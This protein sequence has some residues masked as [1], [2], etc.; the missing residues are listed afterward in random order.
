MGENIQF[1]HI[2]D[3]HCLNYYDETDPANIYPHLTDPKIKLTE[4]LALLQNEK[5]DFLLITGDL[6]HEGTV[7][8]YVSYRR[9]LRRYF[10]DTPIIVSLGNHDIKQ[11]FYRGYLEEERTGDFFEETTIKG[12][13]I[14]TLD[15]SI[16]RQDNGRLSGEQMEWLADVLSTR[17]PMGTILQFHHPIRFHPFIDMPVSDDFFRLLRQSDVIA[18]FCGHTHSGAVSMIGNIPQI[19]G[20]STAFSG[21]IDGRQLLF[22]D[23]SCYRICEV[24][25]NGLS[26]YEHPLFPHPEKQVRLDLQ[27]LVKKC[28]KV[29][30][31][32]KEKSE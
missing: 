18:I 7:E 1:A 8:D 26:V 23:R 32:N 28:A 31:L 4:C 24:S 30:T 11:A 3:T 19:V 9:T 6:V 15:S 27:A 2:T 10:P 16:E 5:L 25:E 12:L 29:E 13:R 20:D 21:Q 22:S 17:A 14:V